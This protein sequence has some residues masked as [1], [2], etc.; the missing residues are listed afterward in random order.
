MELTI[1]MYHYVRDL[2]H[3]RYPAIKGL[4]L[5]LFKGQISYL[6]KHYNFVTV[7]QVIAARHQFGMIFEGGGGIIVQGNH[8]R[9]KRSC[10]LSM[11]LIST[12]LQMFFLC[13]M[14]KRY[15]ALFFRR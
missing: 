10:L 4:D 7:E 3:S 2:A 1:V 8:F 9:P 5:E 11:M 15:K 13:C 6:Q 12:T 14:I